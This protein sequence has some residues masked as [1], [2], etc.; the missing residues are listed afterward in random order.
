MNND[1]Q[2]GVQ[3]DNHCLLKWK[4]YM[5][6]SKNVTD[7]VGAGVGSGVG[8]GVGVLICVTNIKEKPRNARRINQYGCFRLYFPMHY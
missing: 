5:G 8:A 6:T 4:V 1:K 7:G 3:I 2:N